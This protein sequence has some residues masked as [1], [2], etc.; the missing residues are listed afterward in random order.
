MVTDVADGSVAQSAGFQKG[1]IVVSLNNA[2][3]A[4]MRDLLRAISQP[5]RLW[6]LTIVRGGQEIS[7]VFGG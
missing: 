7:A 6:R 1:D 5:M 3:I 4:T 2:E